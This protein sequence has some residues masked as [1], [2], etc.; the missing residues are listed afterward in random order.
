MEIGFFLF[1]RF[2]IFL[3]SIVVF[4]NCFGISILYF[5]FLGNL[6]KD[7]FVNGFGIEGVFQY[8]AVFNVLFGFILL[9]WVIPKDLK[10]IKLVSIILNLTLIAFLIV[11]AVEFLMSDVQL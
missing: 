8:P 3:I 1:G 2:S 6:S 9:P 7:V 5:I 4:M 11:F 10:D